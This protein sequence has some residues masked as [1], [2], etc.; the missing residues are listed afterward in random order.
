MKATTLLILLAT[1]T[2]LKAEFI[3]F[4]LFVPELTSDCDEPFPN[5]NNTI[6]IKAFNG[7]TGPGYINSGFEST[8]WGV[9]GVGHT[10]LYLGGGGIEEMSFSLELSSNEWQGNADISLSEGTILL[11]PYDMVDQNHRLHGCSATGL[12]TGMTPVRS[13]LPGDLDLNGKFNS[14][15]LTGAFQ[16]GKWERDDFATWFQGDW[17]G[18]AR[19]GTSDLVAAFKTGT[20]NP[21]PF[22]AVPV[23]Y[24]PEP[25]SGLI[26]SVL[27]VMLAIF[28]WNEWRR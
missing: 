1:T 24:V 18:D 23:S 4:R 11:G 16:G 3:T 27:L 7:T 9:S 17:D 20:Y 6:G 13:F 12:V 26:F 5:D 25:H 15:D 22:A 10:N 8:F 28:G 21:N 14:R 2:S 19:F